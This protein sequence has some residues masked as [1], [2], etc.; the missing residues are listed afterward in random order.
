M[1]V[2]RGGWHSS[3]QQNCSCGMLQQHRMPNKIGIKCGANL[4]KRYFRIWIFKKLSWYRYSNI[5]RAICSRK[6]KFNV[7]YKSVAD[8]V[9][10]LRIQSNGEFLLNFRKF[11][12]IGA[13]G[14][15]CCGNI[16]AAGFNKGFTH[17]CRIVVC[18]F[19]FLRVTIRITG[20]EWAKYGTQ[21]RIGIFLKFRFYR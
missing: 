10:H 20:S 8:P 4:G 13:K 7:Q 18:V 11:C 15:F 6:N 17:F 16:S 3:C 12:K 2:R 1:P 19:K 14:F 21:I 5:L 9:P